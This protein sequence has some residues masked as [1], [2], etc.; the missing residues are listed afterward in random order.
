MQPDLSAVLGPKLIGRMT[1]AQQ[2]ARMRILGVVSGGLSAVAAFII[3]LSIILEGG[4]PDTFPLMVAGLM[5]VLVTIYQAINF[6]LGRKIFRPPTAEPTL[7]PAT[8]PEPMYHPTDVLQ[9]PPAKTSDFAVPTV[10]EDTTRR[11]DPTER[12][13][14]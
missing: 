5:C 2:I 4:R 10:T 3:I 6:Y 7:E 8:A 13:R 12:G 11:L 14:K 1:R 9:M